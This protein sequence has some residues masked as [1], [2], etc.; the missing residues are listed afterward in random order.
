MQKLLHEIQK[1]VRR[2]NFTLKG[3]ATSDYYL[4]LRSL[5][6]DPKT[7][8][9]I[10]QTMVQHLPKNTTCIAA[11]GYGGIP[12]GTIISQIAKIPLVLVRN[13]SKGHGLADAI[14]GYRPT[15]KDRI[16]IVDDICTSGTSISDTMKI[17]AGCK[18]KSVSALVLVQRG[19]SR[20]KISLKRVF[21]I[22]DI[23]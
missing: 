13:E 5:Y 21:A 14:I 11:S 8:K 22:G 20:N 23:I 18:P 3:G 7:L 6:G 4:D 10:G 15:A 9:M 16:V 12:L 17:L 1:T 19:Q 2:G